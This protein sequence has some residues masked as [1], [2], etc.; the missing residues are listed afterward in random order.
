MNKS[1][2]VN[3]INNL[4][5]SYKF[6]NIFIIVV[7]ALLLTL[8]LSLKYYFFQSVI[9]SDNTS[10]KNIVAQKTIDV[11]DTYKT[12]LLKKEVAQKIDPILT[13]ADDT[14]IKNNYLGI[15]KTIEV[16]RA[17]D[18]SIQTKTEE[19]NNLFDIANQE[20]K[21][22]VVNYLLTESEDKFNILTDR[23]SKLLSIIL[24]KGVTEKDFDSMSVNKII[25]QNADKD[26][27]RAQ[28]SVINALLEQVIVPNMV[29]DEAA[30][31]LARKN[32]VN[33]VKPFVVT[34][35][36]GETIVYEGEPVT[37]LKKDALDKVGYNVLELNYKGFLSIWALVIIGMIALIYYMQFFE[38][39]LLNRNSLSI[40]GILAILLVLCA[41]SIPE[42]ASLYFIPIP[43]F[44][45]LLAIFTS[46]RIAFLVSVLMI[47]LIALSL[48]VNEP[49]IAVFSMIALYSSISTARIKYSRRFDLVKS[50]FETAIFMVVIIVAIY[51]LERSTY[52]ISVQLIASDIFAGFING[53]LS[54][55]IALGTLPLIENLFKITTP[56]GLAEL[57]DHNQP[58]LK[59]LQFE[60]PGTFSHSLMVSNLCEAAAEAIGAD[61]ILARVGA[62]YHDIGKLK[63][64]LFFVENQTYFGIENPHNKLNP[65]LSK[66]VITAHPKDGVELAREYGLPPV[67]QNFIT[68]HHGESLAGHF[69]TQAIQ[70]E[71]A[72]NVKE[73]QFRY[74]G[75][76]PNMKETAILMIADAI[77][78]ASRTLQDHSQ[79]ELD[80]LINRLI[81]DRL[82]D[83]Q[84][85]DSTLTLRDLKVIANT[86]NRFIRASH[87]QR[88]IYH[89]NIINELNNNINIKPQNNITSKLVDSE[90]EEKIEKK[91][92][93]RQQKNND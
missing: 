27:S 88:I 20:Q 8:T 83:G 87:H 28:L 29:V 36:K 64:P 93:K 52:D 1:K 41:V 44:T 51:S 26:I 68:Q 22:Y 17:K 35:H 2:F 54:G 85:A 72:E 6:L 50:G 16:I 66:M 4:F 15:V 74:P 37:K 30:T 19:L 18:T 60:A 81:Q 76:K 11:V 77:E 90:L 57:G 67:I 75:P 80:V 33:A 32:A 92:Q 55:I 62:L 25:I 43:A 48:Q 42:G 38:K 3:S 58:L 12:E 10:K 79:E 61:P 24:K 73:E 82:N 86:F 65:R 34:F 21:K 84:L 23:A 7:Y 13:P 53:V 49:V 89:Q 69:Y 47:T 31:E 14:Y 5:S 63:R 45:I 40:V 91:I 56:Y 70:Q 46:P 9:N 78:S 39:Q 71:G 59:R